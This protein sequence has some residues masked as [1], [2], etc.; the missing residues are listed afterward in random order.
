MYF[1]TTILFFFPSSLLFS[2][3]PNFWLWHLSFLSVQTHWITLNSSYVL[4]SWYFLIF[5]LLSLVSFCP[6]LTNQSFFNLSSIVERFADLGCSM[7]PLQPRGVH[8]CR[9]APERCP[10]CAAAEGGELAGGLQLHRKRP[11]AAGSNRGWGQVWRLKGIK[12]CCFS[13]RKPT[14]LTSVHHFYHMYIFYFQEEIYL[15]NLVVH[16]KKKQQYM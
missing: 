3:A 8:W 12:Y 1:Y 13:T 6:L 11:A 5:L 15:A 9:Q 4:L 7:S 14:S 10:Y 2:L 16:S